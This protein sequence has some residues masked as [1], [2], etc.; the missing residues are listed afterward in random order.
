MEITIELGREN[1]NVNP[2]IEPL[3][4][5][6]RGKWRRSNV[7]PMNLADAELAGL[8]DLPGYRVSVDTVARRIRVYDPLQEDSRRSSVES[9]VRKFFKRRLE[10]EPERVTTDHPDATLQRW[11]VAMHRLVEGGNARLVGGR[12]PD[13][14]IYRVA[15]ER[16]ADAKRAGLPQEVKA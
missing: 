2:F 16:S 11:L 7:P 5:A 6:R 10:I 13:D 1:K 4:E 15:A 12:F 3:G 8:P 14:V 9:A